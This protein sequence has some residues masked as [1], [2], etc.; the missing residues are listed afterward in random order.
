MKDDEP[1]KNAWPVVGATF[2]LLHAVQAKPEQGRETLKCFDW[3][4]KNGGDT[5]QQLDY[6]ALPDTAVNAIRSPWRTK[7]KDSAWKPVFP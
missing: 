4:F 6:I 7:V 1:G 2:V 5:V 3:A